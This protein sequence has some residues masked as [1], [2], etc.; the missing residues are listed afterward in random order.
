MEFG[1]VFAVMMAG[2]VASAWLAIAKNR[3]AL[4]WAFVG[5]VLPLISFITLLV[6]PA[7]PTAADTHPGY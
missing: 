5:A 6:A 7:L 3:N 4:G 2:A 1:I